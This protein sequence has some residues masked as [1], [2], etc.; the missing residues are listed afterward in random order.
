MLCLETQVYALRS[1]QFTFWTKDN[2]DPACDCT[3][4]FVNDCRVRWST[5]ANTFKILSS[6]L[7]FRKVIELNHIIP[8]GYDA[9]LQPQTSNHKALE[10]HTKMTIYGV[11]E[12]GCKRTV[13]KNIYSKILQVNNN[14][15]EI[16]VE[17]GLM[18]DWTDTRLGIKPDEEMVELDALNLHQVWTPSPYFMHSKVCISL[19][20]SFWTFWLPLNSSRVN[21]A[22]QWSVV[23]SLY[24]Y[25]LTSQTLTSPSWLSKCSASK[26]DEV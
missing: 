22:V 23:R 25:F 11:L 2:N 18:L 5:K 13:L 3:L 14:N 7:F 16:L 19:K 12:V 6:D 4:C 17:V 15:R 10:L 1:D 21:S 26:K 8:K 20:L 9:R 24:T